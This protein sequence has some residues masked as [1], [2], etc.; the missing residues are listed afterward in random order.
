MENAHVSEQLTQ[1]I[2]FSLVMARAIVAPTEIT[3]IPRLELKAA[4]VAVQTIDFLRK[5]L[6][7]DNLH[8]YFWT[9]L[10]VVLGYINNDARRLHVFVA[11]HIQDTLQTTDT[12]KWRYVTSEDSPVDRASR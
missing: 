5:E 9:D 1:H 8:E 4:V 7:I 11:N 10:N 2:H 3:T 12:T 6:E